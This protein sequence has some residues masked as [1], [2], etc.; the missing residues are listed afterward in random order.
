MI[1]DMKRYSCKVPD[2]LVSFHETWILSRDL[3]KNF[4]YNISQNSVKYERNCSTRT[5]RHDAANSFYFG[6][7]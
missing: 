3:K 5:D 4:K 1:I 2:I 6:I 7:L